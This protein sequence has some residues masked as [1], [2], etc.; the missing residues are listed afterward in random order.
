MEKFNPERKMARREVHE[1]RHPCMLIKLAD[2]RTSDITR[3]IATEAQPDKILFHSIL[4][5]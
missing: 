4:G 1:V 3:R 5:R 2:A